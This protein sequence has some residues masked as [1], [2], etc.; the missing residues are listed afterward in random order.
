MELDNRTTLRNG[1]IFKR[2]RGA[3]ALQQCL[4]NEE[5]E[6]QAGWFVASI[7]L[8]MPAAGDVRFADAG[9]YFRC[10]SRSVIGDFNGDGIIAPLG[11][12][13][14]PIVREIDRILQQVSESVE[15]CG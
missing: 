6:A 10:K 14:N 13:R 15:D 12:D 1:P 4:G 9:Q 2:Q 11:I 3:R 5:T 7:V 8:V